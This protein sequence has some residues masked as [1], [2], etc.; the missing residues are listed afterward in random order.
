ML[1]LVF[2]RY[3]C[4]IEQVSLLFLVCWE[5]LSGI[6]VGFVKCFLYVNWDDHVIFPHCVN[7]CTSAYERYSYAEASLHCRNKYHLSMVYNTF[8]ML[9]R[10]VW[11]Y[12][13]E[14]FWINIHEG[15]SSVVFFSCSV[16]WLRYQSIAS[17]SLIAQLVKN[18]PA[19]QE[20]PVRFL[21]WEDPLEKG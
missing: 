13:L 14:E 5:I 15:P 4:Q 6:D 11:L 12:F 2:H 18:P 8:S 9:I 19:M 21:G 17:L 10:S 16:P 7:G 3:L 20:T 1:L